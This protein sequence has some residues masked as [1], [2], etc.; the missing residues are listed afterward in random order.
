MALVSSGTGA[1]FNNKLIIP[2]AQIVLKSPALTS[3]INL[4]VNLCACQDDH[5]RGSKQSLTLTCHKMPMTENP[6]ITG[7]TRE[8]H[9][10]PLPGIATS[11]GTTQ[12]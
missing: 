7:P 8:E 9:P 4:A 10:V 6:I 12:E 2:I 1:Y 3:S 11:L 5:M